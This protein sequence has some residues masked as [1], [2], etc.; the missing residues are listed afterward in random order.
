MPVCPRDNQCSTLPPPGFANNNVA[1]K[2]G[3][4]IELLEKVI[5]KFQREPQFIEQQPKETNLLVAIAQL[6][7]LSTPISSDD[8]RDFLN[9]ILT[10]GQTLLTDENNT[11]L[12]S[13][14]QSCKI[15][16]YRIF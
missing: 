6:T 3:Q 12:V 2:S 14:D 5:D 16:I 4:L 9:N 15:F 8:K 1:L 10:I 7:L 13:P 11:E